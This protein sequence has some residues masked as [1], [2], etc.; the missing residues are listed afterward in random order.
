MRLE[1]TLSKE[2]VSNYFSVSITNKNTKIRISN[3]ILVVSN[4]LIDIWQNFLESRNLKDQ[5]NQWFY[6]EAVLSTDYVT[7]VT[8]NTSGDNSTENNVIINT[9]ELSRDKII[10][11]ES[12]N[13]IPANKRGT[14]KFISNSD[15]NREKKQRI[16][17]LDI[18]NVYCK[19]RCSDIFSLYETPVVID[20]NLNSDSNILAKYLS[21][22]YENSPKLIIRDLYLANTENLRNFRKYILPYVDKHMCN[23]TIQFHWDTATQKRQLESIF[24]NLDGYTINIENVSKECMHESFIESDKY[25]FNIGYRLKLFGVKDDG[26]TQQDTITIT[27]K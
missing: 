16:K 21:K 22:F 9:C 6:M 5:F 1:L 8:L 25:K 14:I 10:V 26:L 13:I 27:R 19:N 17:I 4:E 7:K 2:T 3:N 18:Y 15:F 11:G 12:T 23:I 20:V 24:N